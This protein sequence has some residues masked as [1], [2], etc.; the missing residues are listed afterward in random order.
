MNVWIY[1]IL[2]LRKKPASYIFIR[3]VRELKRYKDYFYVKYFS[4]LY[5]ERRLYKHA[6]CKNIQELT[7]KIA[8][9]PYPACV[10]PGRKIEISQDMT[11]KILYL[12][13]CAID[14]KV[15][16]LG[17]A[18]TD[19]GTPVRWNTDFKTGAEWR[20]R[21]A[22]FIEY[23]NIEMPSD[24]KIPW[25]LSRMQ[26][27]I[28]V[29]Q[30]YLITGNEEYARFTKEVLS[31]WI[32]ENPY[33]WS[34]NWAC[35]MDVAIRAITWTWF[36]QVY[37]NSSDWD[38]E[39]FKEKFLT[40]LFQHGFFIERNLELSDINGNHYISD[41]AGLVFVGLFF[42]AGELAEKWVK[43]GWNILKSE[44]TK[45]INHD[46]AN[47]EG[48][49][50]YHRLSLE[51]FLYPAIYLQANNFRLQQFYI[52]RLV[53]MAGYVLAYTRPDGTIPLIGDAD[54]GRLL[55]FGFR[56][57][58]DHRYLAA[59]VGLAFQDNDLLMNFSGPEDE[60]FW[61]YGKKG[62]VKLAEYNDKPSRLTSRS[63]PITGKYIMR[64]EKNHVFINCGPLGFAGRGGHSHNDCLSFELYLD[65]THLIT[66]CGAFV[67]T[68][69]YEWRNKFRGTHYHNTP[70]INNEEQNRF[71]HPKQLWALNYDAIPEITKW[72][73]TD[74]M[75]TFIGSHKGYQR[76]E[77]P[78]N[79]VRKIVLDKDNDIFMVHDAFE[80]CLNN[81]AVIPYHLAEGIG[82][83]IINENEIK[84]SGD[85]EFTIYLFGMN[86]WCISIED[87]WVSPSYGLKRPIKK[88]V[89]S[90]S[91]ALAILTVVI[92]KKSPSM[93]KIKAW[94]NN[95]EPGCT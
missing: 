2:Q 24:V 95:I 57:I 87:G 11:D 38:D 59:L 50:P 56:D 35:T 70:M 77:K 58:N 66:D 91:S 47:F 92:S 33:A 8:N 46:G 25:E 89:F 69:S 34:V 93:K 79:P 30:A 14:K 86:N 7:D 16:F 48:S 22:A 26:W 62:L 9:L 17:L 40:S 31:Q 13:D 36:Y 68:A 42:G 29:G 71:I 23:N 12:A 82:A 27:L 90:S 80:G 37:S 64:D 65:N 5:N 41:A 21:Y 28:P 52:D 3:I 6:G 76:L 67:Y 84:L 94:L 39:S 44:I 78:V 19:I 63:F 20:G 54:D 15:S 32:D 45:Q 55:P 4:F 88:I 60:I 51:I 49:I 10:N 83:E 43:T 75:D 1:R 73:S 61:W 81:T 18:N 53:K 85:K 74:S 72:N